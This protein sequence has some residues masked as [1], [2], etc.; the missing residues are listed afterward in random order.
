[1]SHSSHPAN[2]KVKSLTGSRKQKFTLWFHN[3][4]VYTASYW[5]EGSKSVFSVLNRAT[6]QRFT[7]PTGTYPTFQ[8]QY[9]MKPGEIV[10][11]T[12]TSSGKPATPAI[13]CRPDEVEETKKF[14]GI[15]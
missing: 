2:P 3:E 8:A 13:N 11:E 9:E 12:G 6:G 15:I 7:P 5:D 14:L 1:M 10:I 4:T